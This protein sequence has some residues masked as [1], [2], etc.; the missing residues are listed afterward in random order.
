MHG[1]PTHERVQVAI[2]PFRK[3]HGILEI[4]MISTRK[5]KK[6]TVPKKFYSGHYNLQIAAAITASHEAGLKGR[7]STS[8]IGTYIY[9]KKDIPCRV[10]VF[11]MEVNKLKKK[12]PQS[13][14]KRHWIP[15]LK[16][17][18]QIKEKPLSRL[19]K[20]LPNFLLEAELRELFEHLPIFKRI[21]Q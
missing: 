21:I 16:A 19:L 14:R 6:W 12:W 9:L 1:I 10:H 13:D 8:T 17:T 4:L 3:H 11:I 20:N 18:N 15:L 7:L 5:E 2:I